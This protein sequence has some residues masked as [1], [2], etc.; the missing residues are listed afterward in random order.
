MTPL[1]NA[2]SRTLYWA[3]TRLFDSNYDLAENGNVFARLTFR[4]V[5]GSYARLETADGAWTFKRTGFWRT[6]ATVRREGSETDLAVFDHNTWNG[7]GTLALA[8]GRTFRV[9]TN[10]WQSRIE[11]QS[12]DGTPLFRYQTEGF[13][14]L[15]AALEVLPAGAAILELPW[16]LG[17]GWYLV[18]MTHHDQASQ[19]VVIG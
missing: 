4:S 17:F 3:Q 18:V 11:F 8:G 7:G 10:F 16:L 13:M 9:T 12:E 5:F 6:R 15:G 1:T 2:G 14:R 19:A